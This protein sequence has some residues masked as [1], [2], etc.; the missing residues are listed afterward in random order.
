MSFFG[1]TAFGPENFLKA[2]LVNCGCFTLYFDEDY[3]RE[4]EQISK[5]KGNVTVED[6]KE[7][8]TITMGF[9]P[10]DEEVSTFKRYLKKEDPSLTISFEELKAALDTVRHD[11][12]E[13]ASKS[14]NYSSYGA[15]CFDCCKHRTPERNL[16]EVFKSPATKGMTY[17]FYKFQN[18]NLNNIH[19]PICKCAETK[20]AESTIRNGVN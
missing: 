6:L 15:Y 20:Y 2:T 4:Y 19:R 7:L 10:L 16:N 9:P 14:V 13:A 8:M 17:G 12:N 1:L 18:T 5:K 11:L 3:L